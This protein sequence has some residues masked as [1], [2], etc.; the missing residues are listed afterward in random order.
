MKD[1]FQLMLYNPQH[2]V[3]IN[4]N[5][6]DFTVVIQAETHQTMNKI[7]TLIEGPSFPDTV[8]LVLKL[9]NSNAFSGMLDEN[10]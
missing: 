9:K 7:K 8:Q 3:K 1:S 2:D 4:K 6:L 10:P 5:V